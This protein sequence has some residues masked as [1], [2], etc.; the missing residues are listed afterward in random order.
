MS[1]QPT[2]AAVDTENLA[3][4]LDEAWENCEP[5]APLSES[6]GLEN[7]DQAYAIQTS[8]SELRLSRGERIIGR[9][10]GLTSFAMQEQLGVSEPD[11]GSLWESR[12]FPAQGGRAE[13][14]AEPL[15][16]PFLEGELAFLIGRPLSGPGVT[17]QTALAA[18]EALAVAVE[19]VDSRIEDWNIKLPDT[20]A[21]NASYGG[22]TTG[23]WSRSLREADLRTIGM[24]INKSGSRV[25]E[26]MG[27][28]SLGHPVKAVAW[29][30]NKLASF[31]TKLE[32]GDIV[33]SGSLGS[34]VPAQRG[35]VFV[36]E[37][38]GQPPLTVS[39]A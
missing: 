18:T 13:I 36:L 39:F 9:K 30:A 12:Y 15:L 21:D 24:L 32:P 7:V 31:G 34:A 29:L 5:I 22:F 3:R 19:V 4:R 8:W 11:Y 14:A 17:L 1:E 37:A 23:P 2:G 28:A 33:L 26:G 6:E 25:A 16:Q 10:I 35:D 27:A 20:I 38:Y